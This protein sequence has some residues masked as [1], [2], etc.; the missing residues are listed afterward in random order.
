MAGRELNDILPVL[1]PLLVVLV[2][3]FGVRAIAL[4][5][6]GDR[7]PYRRSAL[8]F[9]L[10][11]SVATALVVTLAPTGTGGGRSV[12][13]L[14]FADIWDALRN[15]TGADVSRTTLGGNVVLFVP[16]GVSLAL[17]RTQL[18]RALLVI[19]GLTVAIEIVQGITGFGRVASVDDVLLNTAGGFAGFIA[20]RLLLT[21]L[22]T[23]LVSR[24]RAG[25]RSL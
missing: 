22:D 19:V 4:D 23:T 13:L 14:P 11:A 25:T 16:L 12:S 18:A 21:S 5:R 20:G 1:M 17:R 15:R 2:A 8:D 6:R 24:S 10:A 9:L 7:D 3:A